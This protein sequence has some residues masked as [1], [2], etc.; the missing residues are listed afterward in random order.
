MSSFPIVGIG[1]SAG[2]LQAPRRSCQALLLHGGPGFL[3]P[4]HGV[5]RRGTRVQDGRAPP[6]RGG[7]DGCAGFDIELRGEPALQSGGAR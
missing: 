2:G 4:R 1:A 7:C 5:S 3:V 6:E